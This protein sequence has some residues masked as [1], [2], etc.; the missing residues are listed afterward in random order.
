MYKPR[1]PGDRAAASINTYI[2]HQMSLWWLNILCVL[3]GIVL[4]HHIYPS[5]HRPPI[6]QILIAL[7]MSPSKFSLIPMEMLSKSGYIICRA[8]FFVLQLNQLD[9]NDAVYMEINSQDIWFEISRSSFYFMLIK[10]NDCTY[11][12][13]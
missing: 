5:H 12:A 9:K 1:F 13:T 2:Y 7:V 3:A 8:L 6:Q 11:C 4:G 10:L